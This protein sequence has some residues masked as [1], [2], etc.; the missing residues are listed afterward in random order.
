VISVWQ[1]KIKSERGEQAI[2]G[3][4]QMDEAAFNALP[5]DVFLNVP[6]AS[7]F[8]PDAQLLSMGY[9][10]ILPSFGAS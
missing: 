8:A 1:I 10:G 7:A 4:S 2:S 9:S 5:D 6:Q 3:L